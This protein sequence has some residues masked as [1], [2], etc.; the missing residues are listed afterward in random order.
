MLELGVFLENTHTHTRRSCATDLAKG[1][2]A[3]VQLTAWEV[4]ASGLE[5]LIFILG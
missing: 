4:L 5:Q 2:W 3:A 1:G